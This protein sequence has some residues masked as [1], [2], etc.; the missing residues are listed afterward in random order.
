MQI[1]PSKM[2][3]KE[4]GETFSRY[5]ISAITPRL[6]RMIARKLGRDLTLEELWAFHSLIKVVIWE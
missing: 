3:D 6:A 2:T 4:I 1:A 5:E